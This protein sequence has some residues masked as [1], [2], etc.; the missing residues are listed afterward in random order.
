MLIPYIRELVEKNHSEALPVQRP[1]LFY[2]E[3]DEKARDI[4]TEYLLGRDLLICPVLEADALET[5][6][7]LPDDEWIDI[8]TGEEV[9]PGKRVAKAE[10]GFIPVFYRKNGEHKDL[11]RDITKGFGRK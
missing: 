2:Y 6:I 4:S 5:E 10:Y 11:F 9:E 7:Y 8:W 3:S 1:L